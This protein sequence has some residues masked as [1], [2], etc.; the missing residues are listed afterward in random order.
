[1]KGLWNGDKKAV[2]GDG[3]VLKSD[4]YVS[5]DNEKAIKTMENP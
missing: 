4:G 2:T 5:K 1:M 3:K